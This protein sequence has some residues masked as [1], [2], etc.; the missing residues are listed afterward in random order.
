MWLTVGPEGGY[1]KVEQELIGEKGIPLVSLGLRRLRSETAAIAAMAI[2][3]T[4]FQ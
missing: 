3:D 2:C 1:H 4:Y